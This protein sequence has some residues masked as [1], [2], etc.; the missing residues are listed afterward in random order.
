[1][2]ITSDDRSGSLTVLTVQE[3]YKYLPEAEHKAW[4]ALYCRA[5]GAREEAMKADPDLRAAYMARLDEQ[6]ARSA[7]TDG[8]RLER[9][10]GKRA[11]LVPIDALADV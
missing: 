8:L 9:K 4:H 5:L 6:A 2:P 10:P 11:K 3:W 1:M 7:A